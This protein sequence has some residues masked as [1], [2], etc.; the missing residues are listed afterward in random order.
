MRTT[1]LTALHA[2]VN[3]RASHTIGW[4]FADWRSDYLATAALRADR[5]APC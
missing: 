5:L 2:G 3:L 1:I 4:T